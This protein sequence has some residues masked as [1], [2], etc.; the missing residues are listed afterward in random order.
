MSKYTTT[1]RNLIEGGFV[2]R[3]EIENI[4]KSYNM[5]VK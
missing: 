4:F 1:F 2:T 5:L 3:E